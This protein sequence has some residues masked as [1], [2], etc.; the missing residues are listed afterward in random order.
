M[1][2]LKQ[3]GVFSVFALFIFFIFAYLSYLPILG[4]L[5]V[6]FLIFGYLFDAFFEIIGLLSGFRDPV[7][8]R[9]GSEIQLFGP[10]A[11]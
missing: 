3:S 5:D 9:R 6:I 1:Y 4:Y 11:A 8:A 2:L 7:G 10:K